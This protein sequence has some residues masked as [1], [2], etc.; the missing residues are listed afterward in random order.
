G[1]RCN[2]GCHGEVVA[3]KGRPVHDGA[4]QAV[5]DFIEYLLADQKC[6]HWDMSTREG[7]GKKHHVRFDIPVLDREKAAGTP[8]PGLTFIG[9]KQSS[10]LPA[11]IGGSLEVIA[12]RHIDALALDRLDNE[13]RDTIRMKRPLECD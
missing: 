6:R 4:F 1:E 9:N 3:A 10:A 13:C 8:H 2:S 7:L 12:D 5:E 11:E